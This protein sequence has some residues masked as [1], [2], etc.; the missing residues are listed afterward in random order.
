MPPQRMG[1]GGGGGGGVDGLMPLR[2]L[3]GEMTLRLR[4]DVIPRAQIHYIAALHG[5]DAEGDDGIGFDD[6][7]EWEVEER[8]GR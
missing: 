2:Q 6:D 8:K 4:E 3:Q 1:G 5:F 7:G